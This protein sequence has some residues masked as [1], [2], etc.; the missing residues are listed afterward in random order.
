MWNFFTKLPSD[1]QRIVL[2]FLDDEE[3]DK[4]SSSILDNENDVFWKEKWRVTSM[5][6]P[7]SYK[8]LYKTL[9][10]LK[11]EKYDEALIKFGLYEEYVLKN[12][13]TDIL[14]EGLLSQEIILNHCLNFKDYNGE[15]L[16]MRV[17]INILKML[18]RHGADVN[19][20]DSNG[21]TDLLRTKSI[22]RAKIL[23]KYG[24][25]I[26]HQNN[27]GKTI[28][29]LAAENGEENFVSYLLEHNANPYI[30]NKN[31]QTVLTKNISNMGASMLSLFID[32]RLDWN[33]PSMDEKTP[34]MYTV[35]T[36]YNNFLRLLNA[37]ADVDIQDAHGY[38][39]LMMCIAHYDAGY[40][41][42]LLKYHPDLDLQNID[43]DTALMLAIQ[44][45]IKFYV[46]YLLDSG[47]DIHIRNIKNETAMDM[48]KYDKPI[49]TLLESKMGI[50]RNF[51]SSF[52]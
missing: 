4:F 25:N 23:L 44:K 16:I 18:L 51:F 52:F 39:V 30:Y 49:L 26:D 24:A 22:H 1:I 41:I 8:E 31:G 33:Y 14:S 29:M 13:W 35:G 47:A 5:V 50:K 9:T 15:C 34:L 17:D 36:N 48:A 32:C 27:D 11:E 6:N 43:G 40:L 10:L 21:Y 28:L 20:Q 12:T 45:G 19:G 2:L 37:G 38:T 7:P 3:L 42:K 46:K